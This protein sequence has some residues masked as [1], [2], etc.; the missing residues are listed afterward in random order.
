M[1]LMKYL[2]L[3]LVLAVLVAACGKKP[4]GELQTKREELVKSELSLDSLK[5]VISD[6]KTEIEELDTSARPNAIPVM[7]LEIQKGAYQNPF[8][9]QGLVE[10]D[11]NVLLSAEA[12]GNITQVYVKEG[13]RVSKGQIIATVDGSAAAAQIA[14]LEN[15][16][17]L[18]KINFEKQQRLWNKKIGSEM[19]FLQAKNQYENFQ[20]SLA[21]ANTQL[22]KYTLRSPINGTVD[23]IM[24]NVGEYVGSL[25]GGPVVRI[26]DLKD[27]K[28]KA[29]VSEKYLTQIKKG[30]EIELYFP[31]LDLRMKEKVYSVGNVV[32][33]NN[34]TFVVYVKPTKNVSMLRPNLLSMIT[35]YDFQE[36]DIITVPTKLIRNDG[37]GDYIMVIK[38]NKNKNTAEKRTIEIQRKFANNSV[39][40]NGLAP[41]DKIIIE[42][43]NNTVNGDEVKIIEPSKDENSK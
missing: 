42:G 36:S 40:A 34:R 41:G 43:Y 4:E 25:T 26:V 22:A 38:T 9:F 5:T 18:A 2:S 11:K 12:P 29:H 39:I 6:L 15:A 23:E 37:T 14:E 35:A 31:S 3:T 16:L 32:D 8:Q 21:T 27:I 33:V 20:K 1:K 30:Q 17:S 28:V 13:Q 7:V 24:A 19:Q 10:S